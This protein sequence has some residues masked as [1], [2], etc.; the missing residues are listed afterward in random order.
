VQPVHARSQQR[1]SKTNAHSRASLPAGASGGEVAGSIFFRIVSETAPLTGH[2]YF[3][4][5]P[6]VIARAIGGVAFMTALTAA[7][8]GWTIVGSSDTRLEGRRVAGRPWD[9]EAPAATVYYP[10]RVS[11]LFQDDALLSTAKMYLAVPLAGS[12]GECIGYLGLLDIRIWAPD[13]VAR[14]E[15]LLRLIAPRASAEQERDQ[16]EQRLIAETERF[17][18]AN[19]QHGAMGVP[20]RRPAGGTLPD[21]EV[22]MSLPDQ[23]AKIS[24]DGR[25]VDVIM[26]SSKS[27]MVTLFP[28]AAFRRYASEVMPVEA[29]DRLMS[30]VR[31]AVRANAVAMCTIHVPYD[32]DEREYE[33]RVVPMSSEVSLVFVRDRTAERWV[34]QAYAMD[35]R[36][37]GRPARVVRENPYGLTFR[38]VGVLELMSQGASDKEIAS[39]LGVSVFTVYKHVSKILHKM[40]A[41]SRTEASLRTVR[42][43]LFD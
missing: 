21:H 18:E 29:A 28:S 11:Q 31:E 15:S 32:G 14:A 23:V 3:D 22:L 37:D 10:S 5:A 2:A 9:G 30:T 13:E 25:L 19:N 17:H 4:G 20:N 33:L 26:P 38:E 16:L 43:G 40:S 27:N 6:R 7:G 1:P 34:P 36:R 39:K 41:A 42:E 8:D 35:A 24:S 12:N